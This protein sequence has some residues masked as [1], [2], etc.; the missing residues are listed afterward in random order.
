[1]S[2]K[3]F[4]ETI[5]R[6]HEGLGDE[7]FEIGPDADTESRVEV[8]IKSADGKSVLGRMTFDPDTVPLFAKALFACADEIINKE[9]TK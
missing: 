4:A 5:R 8:L 6:V 3:A 7:F 9:G 1:M 2:N